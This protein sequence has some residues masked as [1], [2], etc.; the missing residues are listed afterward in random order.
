MLLKHFVNVLN[1]P[2]FAQSSKESRGEK[3]KNTQNHLKCPEK[4]FLGI[5]FRKISIL[6]FISMHNYQMHCIFLIF[7]YFSDIHWTIPYLP[8]P[9]V[10]R[11]LRDSVFHP[12]YDS[13]R[14]PA[15]TTP[16]IL[17]YILIK[18]SNLNSLTNNN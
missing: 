6:H 18:L 14:T 1:F 12:G 15:T 11:I 7:W 9:K 5:T 17:S 8:P 3:I 4:C 16:D 13:T 2:K 10:I